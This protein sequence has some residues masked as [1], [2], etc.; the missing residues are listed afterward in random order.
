MKLLI[1]RGFID[2]KLCMYDIKG[3]MQIISGDY[4]Y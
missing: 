2:I 1:L 4:L 3:N